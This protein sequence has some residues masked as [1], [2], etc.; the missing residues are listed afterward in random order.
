M[1]VIARDMLF[2]A[3]IKMLTFQ[4]NRAAI[5]NT[6]TTTVNVLAAISVSL[7]AARCASDGQKLAKP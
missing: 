2:V 3:I 5:S 7:A 4:T 6:P 1:C